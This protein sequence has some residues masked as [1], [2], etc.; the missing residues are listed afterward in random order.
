MDLPNPG[1]EP[2]S[3]ALA[4]GFFAAEPP[5]KPWLWVITFRLLCSLLPQQKTLIRKSHVNFGGKCHLLNWFLT[6]EFLEDSDE[7]YDPSLIKIYVKNFAYNFR[8]YRAFLVAQ[9][10]KNPPTMQET[11]VPFLDWED[12]LEKG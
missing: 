10:V 12:P 4:G 9:L 2:K 8:D 1:I 5:G 3:P 6:L 7:N 11:W